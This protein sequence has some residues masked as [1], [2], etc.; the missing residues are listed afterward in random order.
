MIELSIAGGD[1]IVTLSE[2]RAEVLFLAYACSRVGAVNCI[3]QSMMPAGEL[4]PIVRDTGARHIWCSPDMEAKAVA[5]AEAA[6][7][8]G[9]PLGVHVFGGAAD[10]AT[11]NGVLPS[12]AGGADDLDEDL[13]LLQ[14]YT[15]GTTGAP[16]GVVLSHRAFNFSPTIYAQVFPKKP[17]PGTVHLIST[18]MSHIG[19]FGTAIWPS[20]TGSTAIIRQK[21]DAETLFRDLVDHKVDGFFAVP[22]MLHM[23]LERLNDFPDAKQINLSQILYGAAPMSVELL[24]RAQS[25]FD[26]A[27]V[28]FYGLTE[29]NITT[30]LTP[31]DHRKATRG[32]PD[33]LRSV[34]RAVP[35]SEVA[36]VDAKG[37]RLPH[38]EKGEIVVRS[39][40]GML[41]YWKRPEEN[42]A[43]IRDGWVHTG[44]IGV[45][46]EEGYLYL[47]DRKKDMIISGGK[48]IY[49][50]EVEN[51]LHSHP[52]VS[53]VAVIGVPHETM[54][55]VLLALIVPEQGQAPDAEGLAEFC[56]S[57]IAGY[58]IPRHVRLVGELPRN[59][60]GK[61]LKTR[62]RELY[63]TSVPEKQEAN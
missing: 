41:E 51:V 38:G 12:L 40:T 16:K 4:V 46:D 63:G 10:A 60:A 21:F 31:A 19:G 37:N 1:R 34:G 29:T 26:C 36:I 59:P 33:I 45:L 52:A 47:L 24:Q 44:D 5:V 2:N 49:P 48:N 14:L 22:A 13:A 17:G 58:K 39:A 42:A 61:V 32:R 23:L 28:Q 27:F 53:Q 56:S 20:M 50:A 54:G 43:T 6:G 3:L 7:N 18:P 25:A 35:C 9:V 62:L 30:A 57:R 15:S 8:D 55:E 11:A